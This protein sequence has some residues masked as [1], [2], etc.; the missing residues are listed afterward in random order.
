ME[1]GLRNTIF[2][3]VPATTWL[4]HLTGL[5]S[6]GVTEPVVEVT[7]KYLSRIIPWDAA[8]VLGRHTLIVVAPITC[9]QESLRLAHI[10]GQISSVTGKTMDGYEL[11][12]FKFKHYKGMFDFF[13]CFS[14]L[15][16]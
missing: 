2:I 11:F 3:T 6:K 10:T 14:L 16:L 7:V 4:E 15:Y 13:S 1:D 12:G 9:R 8:T 5:M